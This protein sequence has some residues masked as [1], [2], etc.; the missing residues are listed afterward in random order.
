MNVVVK[1]LKTTTAVL[2]PL[3]DLHVGHIDFDEQYLRNTISWMVEKGAYTILLGDL[4]D[5]IG[6]HDRR[7]EN[8]SIAP[9]FREHLDNLHH[10]QVE[11]CLDLL[12]PLKEADLIIATLGGN[13]E[14]TVLKQYSYD[15]TNVIAESLGVPRLTDPGYVVFGL[16]AAGSR[17]SA[18]IWCSHGCFLGGRYTGACVNAMERLSQD[19]P[20]CN[21]YMAGHSH[22][23]FVTEGHKIKLTKN[24][25]IV[26][27]RCYFANTGAFLRTYQ[28][29][30]NDSWASRKVF[31]PKV[32]GVVRFDFYIKTKNRKR[33]LDIHNRT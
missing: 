17:Y 16:E 11:Y 8:A 23:K 32:P 1:R 19:F 20:S 28:E 3:S 12:Q 26:E 31:S 29:K 10:E 21:I 27:E 6:R 7:F 4:I 9:R 5:G 13:H 25:N 30:N 14:N 33:Y 24:F 22:R 15:A 18:K 2:V